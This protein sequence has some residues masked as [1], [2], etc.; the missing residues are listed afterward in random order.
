M[1][2]NT[3]VLDLDSM[4]GANTEATS[5][6]EEEDGGNY[7]PDV[8]VIRKQLEGLEGMYSEVSCW[9]GL[10]TMRNGAGYSEVTLLWG[11]FTMRKWGA[12]YSKV[13]LL[14]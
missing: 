7:D 1:T 2:E 3:D 4:L 11:Y 9:L 5:D 13:T 8:N 12:G 14:W 6:E 10:V